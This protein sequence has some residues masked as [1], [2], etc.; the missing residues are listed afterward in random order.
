MRAT[1]PTLSDVLFG[2]ARGAVLGLLYGHADQSFYYREIVRRLA[3]VSRG[4]LQRELDTLSNLGLVSR[5]TSGNQVY[6]S[7][8]RN[9]PIFPELYTL[10]AKTVGVVH[11]LRSALSNIEDRIT[12]AFVY[13]SFARQEETAASDIDLLVI[14]TA[15]L[16]EV[17][18]AVA[19]AGTS[20]GRI[21]NPSVYSMREFKPKLASGNHFLSSVVRGPKVFLIGNEV[22]LRK[23]GRVRVA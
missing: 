3:N 15:T 22:E 20:T 23:M 16:D 8:N 19:A 18:D 10:V 2:K 17:L 9:H 21:I 11:S 13:G 4:T 1:P 6:Y 5:T 12:I 14:G 7:A